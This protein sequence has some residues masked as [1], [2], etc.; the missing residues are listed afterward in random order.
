MKEEIIKEKIIEI[1]KEEGLGLMTGEI[2]KQYNDPV[3]IKILGLFQAQHK[4]LLKEISV[5]NE[6]FIKE[7]KR[8]EDIKSP[9]LMLD[10]SK[11]FIIWLKDKI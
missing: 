11:N 7:V 8:L 4:D 2:E 10:T 5:K 9:I 3:V 6:E 1:L